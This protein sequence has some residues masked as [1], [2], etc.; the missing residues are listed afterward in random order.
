LSSDWELEGS[1]LTFPDVQVDQQSTQSVSSFRVGVDFVRKAG[2]RAVLE[3]IISDMPHI[4]ETPGEREQQTYR[5]RHLLNNP[6]HNR[7]TKLLIAQPQAQKI[8]QRQPHPLAILVSFVV[9]VVSVVLVALG[10]VAEEFA[11]V[12]EVAVEF[13]SLVRGVVQ[14]VESNRQSRVWV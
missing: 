8:R 12:E 5:L 14:R 2:G 11:R 3:S 6:I 1:R 7:I 9:A 4:F 10:V 13:E